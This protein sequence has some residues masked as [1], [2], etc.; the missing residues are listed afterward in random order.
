M[1]NP[2][3]SL[4]ADRMLR[5]LNE[6]N[7]KSVASNGNQGAPRGVKYKT[8]GHETRR[9]RLHSSWRKLDASSDLWPHIFNTNYVV[10]KFLE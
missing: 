10:S 6:G 5:I 8:G 3:L 7:R 1:Q 9:I 4:R 2:G